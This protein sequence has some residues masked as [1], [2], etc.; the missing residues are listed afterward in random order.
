MKLHIFFFA[1]FVFFTHSISAQ[2]YKQIDE[3][4]N[5]TTHSKS[6][7]SDS[8]KTHKEVP[9]GIKV[10]TVD[11]RFGDRIPTQPDTLSHLFMNT[12]RIS[13]LFGTYN[14]TGNNGGARMSRIFIEQPT[15]AQFPFLQVYDYFVKPAEKFHFTNTL[16]PFT[17]L[18]YHSSGDKTDGVDHLTALFGVNA[19]KRIGAGFQFDYLYNRGIY[20]NQNTAHFN[21]TMFGSYIG[22]RYQAHLLASTNHQKVS[23]NG[24]VANDNYITHPESFNETFQPAEIPTVLSQ[25]WN[26]NDN[27]HIFFSHRYNIGFNRKVKMTEDEIKAKKFAIAAQQ[28]KERLT[29][30]KE[31]GN[32]PTTATDMAYSGRP[33]NARIAG[34]EPSDTMVQQTK[35]IAVTSQAVA[36][37][38]KLATQK[39]KNDTTWLKNEYVPVTSIIHTLQF[40]NYKRIYQAHNTSDNFYET[41]FPKNDV[42]VDAS[43]YD[44]TRHYALRNTFALS[45]LEGFNKWAKAGVKVFAT[46][47]LR[48]FELP[49][50][51]GEKQTY[52]EHNLSIGGQLSKT[53][54]K[55]LHYNF[56]AETFV[57]GT[58]IG[59]LKVDGNVDVN[60]N[61]FG[62][63]VTLA[64]GGFVHHLTPS[65]YFRHYH[66]KHLWWDN[67]DLSN[68]FHTRIQGLLSYRKTQTTLKVSIDEIKNFTY[69]GLRYT[70]SENNNDITGYTVAPTQS[71]SPMTVLTASLLQD[72]QLGPVHW[73]NIIT[74]QHSTKQDVLPLP[75]F[76]LY[77]NLYLRFK[78][79]KVLKCDLGADITYFSAYQAPE[80]VP[81]MG[82]FATQTNENK[83]KIGNYPFVNAY[84]NF[85]LKNTRFYVR[86]S[87]INSG[88]GTRNYF[89]LPHY[90]TPGRLLEMGLSWTFYN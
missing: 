50:L 56:L 31:E 81:V 86:M 84:A 43:I 11:A 1:L 61:L 24:G 49:G 46:S 75:T 27:Q 63:T 19:G 41:T 9:K 13:G 83:V 65:F 53:Q 22:D 78:I 42:A 87:H 26:R 71:K 35:R 15:P 12:D 37:S 40:D 67:T 80:Y 89:Q 30:N 25:H 16:S 55:S 62:D 38:L 44:L 76:N 57:V 70:V 72:F 85:H 10:W 69:Y 6:T 34:N 18:T 82:Q 23:E 59:N 21:Y 48:H 20:Q 66:S 7:T 68:I 29:R 36:D 17:N 79:A 5:I 47:E 90:P 45:L 4:G 58:D 33:E 74:Y 8:T 39:E 54:G 28:E 52:N 51:S 14:N 60:F 64:A 88:T 32:S 2:E 3:E 77:S 73:E